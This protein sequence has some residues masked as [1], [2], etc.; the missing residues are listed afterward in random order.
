MTAQV[1]LLRIYTDEAAYFGDR[2]VSDEIIDRVRT[3]GLAG[4]TVLQAS[5]GF[6]RG[7]RAHARRVLED[8]QS[9]VIEIVDHED[10]LV[11]FATSIADLPHIGLV[12]L[13]AVRVLH[14]NASLDGADPPR[15][16]AERGG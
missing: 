4:I 5:V 8:E 11:A 7:S 1:S 3:A 12:T 10:E 2:P 15:G 16:P 9:L 13:E 6:R 14:A